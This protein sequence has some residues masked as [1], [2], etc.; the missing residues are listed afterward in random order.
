MAVPRGLTPFKKGEERAKEA[1]RKGGLRSQEIKREQASMRET[2]KLLLEVEDSKGMTFRE[3]STLGL[4]KGAVDGK[5]ENY[6]IIL[7]LLGELEE[8]ANETPNVNINI[9]DNS[10]LEKV[11]YEQNRKED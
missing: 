3:T 4:I 5:A 11:L 2:L 1:G 8:K 6:K 10:D 9:I 7:A